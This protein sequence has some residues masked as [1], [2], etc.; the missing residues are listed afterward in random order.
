MAAPKT[1]ALALMV[2]A[3]CGG[4]EITVRVAN[5][6][7]LSDAMVGDLID[8]AALTL[9]TPI[10]QTDDDPAIEL[11]LLVAEEPS[12]EGAV[13]RTG[14]CGAVIWAEPSSA[15]I[16][17]ELGHAHGLHHVDEPGNLMSP[18]A[19]GTDLEDWQ[20]DTIDEYATNYNSC[21]RR[22]LR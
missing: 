19:G 15:Y 7:S 8:R 21:L 13:I 18:N 17:H 11:D 3:A 22:G 12:P 6:T 5:Y 14:R 9:R 4:G 10:V 16:A 1:I 20:L 2:M